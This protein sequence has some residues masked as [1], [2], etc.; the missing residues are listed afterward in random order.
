M[1]VQDGVVTLRQA[2]DA[3]MSDS[4]V[5]RRVSSGDWRRMASGVYLRSDRIFG[6]AAQIRVAVY[7]AGEGAV[8]YGPSAAWWHGML[9]KPPAEQW[10]TIPTGRRTTAHRDL[11]LRRRN[12][13]SEDVVRRRGLRL[14]DVPLTVL[15]TAVTIPEGSVFM[16]R[17][18]QTR[19]MLSQ[20]TAAQE[21]NRGRAGAV[22]AARLLRSAG[23]GG[24][25]EAERML[26]RL[27][28]R[29]GITGWRA[30]VT[31]C[32]FQIDVVFVRSAVA[33][34]VDGW[35]WHRD[36]ARHTA[37]ANRQN[38]LVNGGWHVLRFTWHQLRHHPES[39]V[40]AIRAALAHRG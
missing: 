27:L 9:D 5:S 2:I 39:V 26:H 12:L 28:R 18:L 16:D 19:V 15:E 30:H 10:V 11:R 23:E 3:G 13:D 1:A 37:D 20:L 4:A 7:A 38:V 31:S 34:E 40:S 35:A 22:A 24:A 29:A 33:I 32:G 6:P 8:M 14:T 25:S 36:A 17:A 21:R